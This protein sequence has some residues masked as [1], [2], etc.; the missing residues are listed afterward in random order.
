M[1]LKTAAALALALVVGAVTLTAAAQEG[2]TPVVGGDEAAVREF[3]AQALGR[4]GASFGLDAVIYIAQLPEDMPFDLP[5][6]EWTR[7]TG[8][9]V[10]ESVDGL[11]L[12]I[13]LTSEQRAR[14]VLD[15]YTEA[16]SA[17]GWR[18]VEAEIGGGFMN[19]PLAAARFCLNEE[20]DINI[21][22]VSRRGS[23][24]RSEVSL[25]AQ[26]PARGLPCTSDASNFYTAPYA[27]LP[28]LTPPDG[29]RMSAS[30]SGSAGGGP[31]SRRA[32]STETMLISSVPEADAILAHYNSQLEAAG[33]SLA[34]TAA[35][36]RVSWSRWTFTN[37]RDDTLWSGVLVVL[38]SPL[39][40][41]E[42][43]AQLRIEEGR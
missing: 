21:T 10:W 18:V 9:V 28:A 11:M 33:W 23:D 14:R 17:A 8:A 31:L 19:A 24:S 27:L 13:L 35:D 15:F 34:D 12:Q 43:Y 25:Y 3:V 20:W 26:N 38:R 30:G 29:V 40:E 41:D 37:P 5:L 22:A 36:A 6:P 1:M 2:S 39:A 42:Y 4:G 16:L 7:V 32:L